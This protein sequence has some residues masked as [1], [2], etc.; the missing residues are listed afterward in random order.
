MLVH[1]HLEGHNENWIYLTAV[2]HRG[3]LKVLTGRESGNPLVTRQEDSPTHL[4][5]PRP[6]PWNWT[7]VLMSNWVQQD[8]DNRP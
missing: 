6:A 5:C 3:F 7:R 1:A 4:V 8:P 2:W